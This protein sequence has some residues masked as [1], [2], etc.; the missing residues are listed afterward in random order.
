MRN[1]KPAR[2]TCL[3]AHQL[4]S[5]LRGHECVGLQDHKEPGLC[6]YTCATVRLRPYH[7]LVPCPLPRPLSKFKRLHTAPSLLIVA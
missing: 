4:A 3:P 1:W 2:A 6:A 7:A 5:R